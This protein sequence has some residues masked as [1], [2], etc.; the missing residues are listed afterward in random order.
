M[1][2]I[3]MSKMIDAEGTLNSIFC[4]FPWQTKYGSIT[5]Q[6]VEGS[7][8]NENYVVSPKSQDINFALPKIE[9]VCSE[10]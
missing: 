8:Y 3:E 4:L 6:D 10:H 9:G 5:Y 7:S 1:D 2:Q